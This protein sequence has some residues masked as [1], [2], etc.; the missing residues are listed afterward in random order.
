MHAQDAEKTVSRSA[1]VKDIC[2]MR[3]Y[4]VKHQKDFKFLIFFNACKLDGHL[5]LFQTCL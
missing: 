1:V 4:I 5:H 3:A 2:L